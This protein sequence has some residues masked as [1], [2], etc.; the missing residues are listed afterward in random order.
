MA[1]GDAKCNWM[2]TP[3]AA[4]QGTSLVDSCQIM[5]SSPVGNTS[6]LSLLEYAF[7]C[8]SFVMESGDDV[9]EPPSKRVKHVNAG[10]CCS[11][12]L[13][14]NRSGTDID[15]H[16]HRFP[17]QEDRRKA[18]IQAVRRVVGETFTITSNTRVCSAHFREQDYRDDGR[19]R[20][21]SRQMVRLHKNAVPS[22]FA[23]KAPTTASLARDARAQ[24]RQVKKVM[25]V[26]V[27]SSAQIVPGCAASP[28]APGCESTAATAA[29]SAIKAHPFL[30]H[31]LT[32]VQHISFTT[33]TG[34]ILM[35]IGKQIEHN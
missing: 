31:Q 12:P 8:F 35:Y 5:K 16:F 21:G 33:S 13:C 10:Y 17:S 23:W 15:R 9:S 18:W 34:T 14:S 29:D 7:V 4:D 20:G 25:S 30:L 32:H 3:A 24:T 19:F 1:T 22:V 11:V 28:A 27:E 26:S 6:H 2:A